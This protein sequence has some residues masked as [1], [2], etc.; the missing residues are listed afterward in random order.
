MGAPE[1]RHGCRPQCGISF[2]GS[3][4]L[5]M[6]HLGVASRLLTTQRQPFRA[7][8]GVSGG[9][10]AAAAVTLLDPPFLLGFVEAALEGRSFLQLA[11]ELSPGGRVPTSRIVDASDRL[12]I[13]VTHCESGQHVLL[14]KFS[15]AEELL[16]AVLASA[17]IPK[18]AHPFDLLGA[19]TYPAS[20]GILV[21]DACRW[22][23]AAGNLPGQGAGRVQAYVDGGLSCAAP[24]LPVSVVSKTL[25]VSPLSGPRGSLAPDHDHICPRETTLCLPFSANLAGLPCYL[26]LGNLQAAGQAMGASRA[27]LQLWFDRGAAD[28]E[29]YLA[30]IATSNAPRTFGS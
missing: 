17:S 19:K 16:T 3:G 27:A 13:G 2:G 14:S 23:C 10:I 1:A 28:A 26:S 8:G 20:E 12:F 24:K 6:Y 9:A 4:H 21:R 22:D 25:T 29:D 18:S 7:I 11:R 5:L 15:D 30:S